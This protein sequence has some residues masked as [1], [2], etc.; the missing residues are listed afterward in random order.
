MGKII[1]PKLIYCADGNSKFA[2][3]AVDEGWLYGARLPATTYQSVYFADQNWK[4]PNRKTYMRALRIYKPK[5]A[6][7]L[8][9]ERESQLPEVLS[10]AE[11]AS[12]YVE[13]VVIIPKVPGQVYKLPKIIN[14]KEIIIGY[15]VP[16]SYG[17]TEV[18][19]E[20]LEGRRVHLLGGS[21][22]KQLEIWCYL[23]HR[24][25]VISIDGNM[26]HK[27]AH[28][29]RWWSCVKGRVGHW[30]QLNEVDD[31]KVG[32]NLEAFRLSLREIRKAW[33]CKINRI[34]LM[35]EYI[36]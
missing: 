29:C 8:D 2:Q 6:T 17:K 36:Y 19:L 18:K 13:K 5:M 1:Y 26:A 21:P 7:V 9:W 25:K 11:E 33:D 12:Q 10:W 22:Q 24:A 3:V 20:E 16:T 31:R 30:R 14:G 27:Q 15:S 32:A 23:L 28:R 34:R 4:D 35:E